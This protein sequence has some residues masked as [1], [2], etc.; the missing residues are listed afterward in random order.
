MYQ[1]GSVGRK[2]NFFNMNYQ[3]NNSQREMCLYCSLNINIQILHDVF[4]NLWSTS[5]DKG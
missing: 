2:M 4:L 3:L 1:Q 5:L